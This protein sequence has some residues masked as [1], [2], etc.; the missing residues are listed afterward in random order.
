MAIPT[1]LR[2]VRLRAR[3]LGTI[4]RQVRTARI[5]Y[6]LPDHVRKDIGWPD[7]RDECGNSRF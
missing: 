4:R 2:T 5:L 6:S 7:A 1:L 3:Q